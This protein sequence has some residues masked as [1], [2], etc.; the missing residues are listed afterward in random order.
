MKIHNDCRALV[1]GGER[2]QTLA[3]ESFS[4][5]ADFYHPIAR[6]M[7]EKDLMLKNVH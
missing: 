2:E 5:N 3:K 7:I 6:A 4:K 1:K